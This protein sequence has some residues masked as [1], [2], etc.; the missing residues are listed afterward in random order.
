LGEE[1]KYEISRQDR[2]ITSR[3]DRGVA[4][5]RPTVHQLPRLI[6]KTAEPMPSRGSAAPSRSACA[7]Q[8]GGAPACRPRQAIQARGRD[9]RDTI[10]DEDRLPGVIIHHDECEMSPV[11]DPNALRERAY[12]RVSPGLD[13]VAGATPSGWMPPP[14]AMSACHSVVLSLTK[15]AMNSGIY[16]SHSPFLRIVSR[17]RGARLLVYSRHARHVAGSATALMS[18]SR[19]GR[20]RALGIRAPIP[21]R[22]GPNPALVTR[23]RA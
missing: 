18:Q 23:L 5:P 7:C 21:L 6:G 4:R 22:I 1:L 8:W 13:F 16:Q 10:V 14:C 17:H 3:P 11:G 15:Y 20:K 12:N 2:G 9:R 19:G